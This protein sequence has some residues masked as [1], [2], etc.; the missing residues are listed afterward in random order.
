MIASFFSLMS[1]ETTAYEPSALSVYVR[2]APMMALKTITS[3]SR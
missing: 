1:H 3:L 2:R